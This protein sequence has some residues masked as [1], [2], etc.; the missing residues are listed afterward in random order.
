MFPVNT[1]AALF[2]KCLIYYLLKANPIFSAKHL[3]HDSSENVLTTA[4]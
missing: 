1:K 4:C 3:R 2:K